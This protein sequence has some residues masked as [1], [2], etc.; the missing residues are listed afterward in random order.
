MYHIFIS[1]AWHRNEHYDTV[2][3]WIKDSGISWKNYSVPKEDPLHSGN[4]AKLRED[5]T[6]Q[7]RP[8]NVVIILCGMY[9]AYSDWIDYEIDE[10]VRMG[11]YIIGVKP[12]GQTRVPAKIQENADVIVGWNSNSVINAITS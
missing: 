12:W 9:A 6:K 8:T 2:E 4:K 5:L 1:H 7:I 10:A 11:K 3:K